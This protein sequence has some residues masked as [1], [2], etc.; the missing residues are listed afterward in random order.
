MYATIFSSLLVLIQ[1]IGVIVVVTCLLTRSRFLIDLH[2]DHPA[3][4]T[5]MRPILVFGIL[6]IYGTVK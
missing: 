2:D 4:K 1:L 6:S 5:Q 3:V